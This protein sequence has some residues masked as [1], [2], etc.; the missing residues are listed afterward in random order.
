MSNHESKRSLDNRIAAGQHRA[1]QTSSAGAVAEEEGQVVCVMVNGEL[2][3][4]RLAVLRAIR[5]VRIGEP[6]ASPVRKSG[7][8]MSGFFAG[9]MTSAAILALILLSR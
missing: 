3:W 2:A 7:D 8:F 6:K 9:I 4:C 1:R 5:H